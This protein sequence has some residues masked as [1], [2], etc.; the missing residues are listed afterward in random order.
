MMRLHALSLTKPLG[1]GR[2]D[3]PTDYRYVLDQG[4][5]LSGAEHQELHVRFRRDRGGAR[6]RVKEGHLT[7]ALAGT[8]F[9]TPFPSDRRPRAAVRYDEGLSPWVPLTDQDPAGGNLDLL[10]QRRN[11]GKLALV[12]GGK[13]LDR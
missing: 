2:Q 11:A 1:D 5:E 12:A 4:R 10:C 8:E 3:A 9:G 13:E 7:E 6:S